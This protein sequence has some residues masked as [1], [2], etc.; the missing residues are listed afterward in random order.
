[1]GK[2]SVGPK[3]GSFFINR[4]LACVKARQGLFSE[5]CKLPHVSGHLSREWSASWKWG[6]ALNSRQAFLW[7]S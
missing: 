1:M 2:L 3:D 5:I 7:V 6:V 4:D